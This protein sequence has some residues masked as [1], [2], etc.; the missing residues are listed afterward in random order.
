MTAATHASTNNP[1]SA[2]SLGASL[3]AGLIGALLS[4]VGGYVV[5]GV[6]HALGVEFVGA[7]N[8]PAAPTGPLPLPMILIANLVPGLVASFVFF[9]F[10][11]ALK[12]PVTP[13]I[14]T[15]GVLAAASVI[16]ALTLGGASTGTRVALAAMHVIAGV[17]IAGNLARVAK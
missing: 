17:C 6:A 4:A 5:Y 7:F 2:V 13:W 3:K 11:K 15:S 9:G 8:G 12:A 14:V 16:P 10:T 1:T